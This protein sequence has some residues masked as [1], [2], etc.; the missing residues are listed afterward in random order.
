MISDVVEG[1]MRRDPNEA[2]RA[3]MESNK[4]FGGGL[5]QKA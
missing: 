2:K 4:K 3:L 5:L 1:V